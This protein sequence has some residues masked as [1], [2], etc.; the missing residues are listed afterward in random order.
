MNT[1][2]YCSRMRIQV[3]GPKSNCLDM[4]AAYKNP[5]RIRNDEKILREFGALETKSG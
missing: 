4:N 3:M 5:A 2:T 1:H